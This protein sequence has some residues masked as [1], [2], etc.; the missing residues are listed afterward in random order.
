M[1]IKMIVY[2]PFW[3]TLKERGEST[4]TLIHKYGISSATIDRIRNGRGITTQKL[5]DLC[6]ILHCNAEDILQYKE[7]PQ[8]RSLFLPD[9]AASKD[10]GSGRK[11]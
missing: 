11:E 1:V 2:D 7:D 9:S 8:E 5:N 6:M 10:N 3:I 4:Y